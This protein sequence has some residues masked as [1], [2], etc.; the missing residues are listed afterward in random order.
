MLSCKESVPRRRRC[1]GRPFLQIPTLFFGIFSA[2]K[3]MGS[4]GGNRAK[5]GSLRFRSLGN[6]IFERG[7][8]PLLS[9]GFTKT[10]SPST[11]SGPLLTDIRAC[12]VSFR[13]GVPTP[14]QFFI[15]YIVCATVC[16]LSSVRWSRARTHA[17][18]YPPEPSFT[19]VPK[20]KIIFVHYSLRNCLRRSKVNKGKPLPWPQ[21]DMEDKE[22]ERTTNNQ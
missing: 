5:N 9:T 19:A 6:N 11:K 22:E 3:K 20:S 18:F 1:Y 10:A 16:R 14:L 13:V 12:V 8:A 2:A 7:V 15:Q 17:I 4:L 21:N